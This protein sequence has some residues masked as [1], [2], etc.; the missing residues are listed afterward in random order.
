MI[1][2]LLQEIKKLKTAEAIL[3]LI[4]T[5]IG[6]YND[7]NALSAEANL[8]IREYFNFDDSE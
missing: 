6:A 7:K 5:D 8:R 2:E 3:K 4:Y 1:D